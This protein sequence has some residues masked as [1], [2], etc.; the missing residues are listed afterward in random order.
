[1]IEL[2]TL[3]VPSEVLA[4]PLNANNRVEEP[5]ESRIN[6]PIDSNTAGVLPQTKFIHIKAK[7]NTSNQP[8]LV[9]FYDTYGIDLKLIGRFNLNFGPSIL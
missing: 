6:I 2:D 4:P 9:E 3:L 5:L 7:F 8:N 1:L